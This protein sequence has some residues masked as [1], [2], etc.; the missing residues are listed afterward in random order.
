MPNDKQEAMGIASAMIFNALKPVP[1]L[2]HYAEDY[3]QVVIE[4]LKRY[5]PCA[6]EIVERDYGHTGT[7]TIMV[8]PKAGVI[9]YR[10]TVTPIY[11]TKDQEKPA[12][13]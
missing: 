2:Y 5:M 9:K 6:A 12:N 1:L 4:F 3:A 13:E 7:R 11:P 8:T 10:V